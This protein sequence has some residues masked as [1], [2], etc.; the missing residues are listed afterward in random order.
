MRLKEWE[1]YEWVGQLLQPIHEEMNH[2]DSAAEILFDA[3]LKIRDDGVDPK[4]TADE[5]IKAYL[6]FIHG[7]QK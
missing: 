3:L 1:F 7:E 4:K 6:K 2:L 5:A